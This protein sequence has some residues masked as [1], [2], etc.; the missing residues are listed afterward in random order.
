MI[1]K[2]VYILYSIIHYTDFYEHLLRWSMSMTIEI[3]SD[4]ER[5][6]ARQKSFNYYLLHILNA[7]RESIF[8]NNTAVF[9][10]VL[11]KRGGWNAFI[12]CIMWCVNVSCVII[13]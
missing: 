6:R 12:I 13:I 1:K 9:I 7:Y 11:K 5:A 3:R 10:Y 2:H 8:T 4:F